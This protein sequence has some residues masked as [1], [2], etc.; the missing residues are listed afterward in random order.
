M[1]ALVITLALGV[2]IAAPAFG[3]SAKARRPAD[4]S[5]ERARIIQKCMEMNKKYNNDPYDSKAGVQNMYN[6]CMANH[7]QPP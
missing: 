4:R 7:G 3:Q 6:A 2:L 1:K 5:N